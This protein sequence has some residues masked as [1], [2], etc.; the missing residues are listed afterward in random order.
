MFNL[1]PRPYCQKISGLV[2]TVHASE[3]I[4]G[5]GSVTVSVKPILQAS[6]ISKLAAIFDDT[7]TKQT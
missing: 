1:V 5:T 3:R 7:E 4:Y 2:S 6:R